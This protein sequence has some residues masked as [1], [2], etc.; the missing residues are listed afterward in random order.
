MEQKQEVKALLDLRRRGFLKYRG[1][2][3]LGPR[4]CEFAQAA[5]GNADICDLGP[6][7]C[8]SLYVHIT[9][10]LCKLTVNAAFL[11]ALLTSIWYW[12]FNH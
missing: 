8:P 10:L 5:S 3:K 7:F 6:P 4:L 1:G 11:V 2:Q 9:N 12:V